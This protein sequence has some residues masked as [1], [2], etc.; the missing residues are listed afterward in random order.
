MRVLMD[1]SAMVKNHT[2]ANTLFFYVIAI[3]F[4]LR[5]QGHALCRT[6]P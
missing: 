5:V 1:N 6:S 4:K 3:L 2:D